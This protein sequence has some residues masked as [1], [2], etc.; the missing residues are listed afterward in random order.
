MKYCQDLVNPHINRQDFPRQKN[1]GRQLGVGQVIYK[2]SF[3]YW[4][5]PTTKIFLVLLSCLSTTY[6]LM[7]QQ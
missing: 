3:I 2:L 7:M 4:F 6:R 5:F 1:I